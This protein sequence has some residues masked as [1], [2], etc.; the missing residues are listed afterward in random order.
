M[1]GRQWATAMLGMVLASS[2][3]QAANG[4]EASWKSRA[5]LAN[6]RLAAPALLDACDK[7]LEQAFKKAKVDLA[8]NGTLYS[9][10]I[11][12]DGATA[13]VTYAYFRS[14]D[15]D[16]FAVVSLPPGWVVYQKTKSKTLRFIVPG[17]AK[18]AFDLCTDGPTAEGRCAEKA[19]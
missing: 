10:E 2:A 7:A 19:P 13:L 5:E 6:R 15:L 8:D 12:I 17:S 9:L 14:G 18:C 16:S 1:G 3:A 11:V 4:A